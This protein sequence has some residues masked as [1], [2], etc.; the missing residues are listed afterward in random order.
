MKFRPMIVVDSREATVAKDIIRSLRKMGAIVQVKPLV[1]GDYI[2]SE[3]LGVERKTVNDFIST[4]TR[5]DLF[6]QVLS[7]KTVY[8]RTILVLEGDLYLAMNFR[9]IHPNALLGTLATL[10]RSGIPVVPTRGKDETARFLFF[11]ARQEQRKEGGG[12]EV[13][14]VKKARSIREFQL[15]MISSLPS[16]GREKAEAILKTFQTPLNALNNFRAWKRRIKGIGV[17]TERRIEKVLLTPFTD[18]EKSKEPV[19]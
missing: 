10:A 13:K 3:E 18:E 7:L 6:E 8:T 17:E 4:L 9:R 19:A 12:F 14:V 5:R 2:L 15:L 1:A 16:I 11:A